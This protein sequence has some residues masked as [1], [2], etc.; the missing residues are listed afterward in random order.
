M[1]QIIMV[2]HGETIEN[3]AGIHQGQAVGGR[4][5]QKGTRQAELTGRALAAE[6]VSAAYVSPLS[7]T[8]ETWEV[9]K[10]HLQ[11]ER[12]I[13]SDSLLAKN[14]GHFG[15]R[16]RDLML[17]HAATLGISIEEYRPP[18]GESSVDLQ[19]RVVNFL[20][21]LATDSNSL[22]ITHGGVIATLMLAILNR[23]FQAYQSYVPEPCAITRLNNNRQLTV[24]SFNNLEHL[25]GET[26]P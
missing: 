18:N 16:R 12:V 15:G 13:R 2:K 6:T 9:I 10:R 25:V 17:D 8:W 19:K 21:T 11:F 7:R 4:L 14:S 26:H 23:T 5:T 1:G 24:E 22:I 20:D 3:V